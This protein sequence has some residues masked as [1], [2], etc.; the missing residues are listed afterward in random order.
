MALKTHCY[1][2]YHKKQFQIL[3]CFICP[4]PPPPLWITFLLCA[5]VCV[6]VCEQMPYV[7]LLQFYQKT[8]TK[9]KQ[10]SGNPHHTL[11]WGAHGSQQPRSIQHPLQ[12]VSDPDCRTSSQRFEF[13]SQPVWS[14]CYIRM[15][16]VSKHTDLKGYQYAKYL[17]IW[18]ISVFLSG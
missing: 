9:E 16:T 8:Q 1:K 6:H 18:K 5:C 10:E 4:K 13:G 14:T 17:N 2:K 15:Y 12:C 11:Q 3:S 7:C